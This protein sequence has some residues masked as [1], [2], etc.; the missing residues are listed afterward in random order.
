MFL[1]QTCAFI[2]IHLSVFYLFIYRTELFLQGKSARC[3]DLKA[4]V[5]KLL[6]KNKE[7]SVNFQIVK[8]FYFDQ[9]N[10]HIYLAR[11]AT[12]NCFDSRNIIMWEAKQKQPSQEQNLEHNMK[13]RKHHS[14]W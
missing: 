7:R 11:S 12:P 4:T 9:R 1:P 3:N 8:Q 2:N 10:K 13:K 6:L 5:Y 14:K